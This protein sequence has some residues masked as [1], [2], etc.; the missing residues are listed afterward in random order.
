MSYIIA[1]DPG[2]LGAICCLSSTGKIH[3]IVDTPTVVVKKAKGNKTEY[4]ESQMASLIEDLIPL[5]IQTV[6]I[7]NVHSMPGQGVTSMFSMG[8]G[9]GLWLGIIA[10]LKLPHERIEPARWK[11]EMEIAAG[12]DKSVSIITAQRMFPSASALIR[13]KK[14]DGRAEALLLAEWMRRRVF[15]PK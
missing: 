7:E 12:S 11:K 2:K 4:L 9:F 1:I 3:T 15:G 13:L 5:G 8:T 6:A 14:H 10:T